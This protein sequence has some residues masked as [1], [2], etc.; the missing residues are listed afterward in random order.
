MSGAGDPD[1]GASAR[2]RARPSPVPAPR[3]QR[4]GRDP[5]VRID[6]ED[7]GTLPLAGQPRPGKTLSLRRQLIWVAEEREARDTGVYEVI[8]RACGD[9]P[10]VDFSEIPP[11]LQQIRGPYILEAGLAAYAEHLGL[12]PGQHVASPSPSGPGNAMTSPADPDTVTGSRRSARRAAVPA[13]RG[14]HDSRDPWPRMNAEGALPLPRAGQPGHGKTASL[15]RQPVRIA[16]GRIEGGYT[17]VFELICPRL[18]RSSLS[19]L[20]RGLAS[21]SA[22]PRAVHDE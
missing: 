15:R 11:R 10:Y 21:A 12:E 8:C 1:S 6:T 2:S 13:A 5:R 4:H 7:V 17:N 19:G 16:D 22:D 9:H 14:Q 3:E 18:R 20:L